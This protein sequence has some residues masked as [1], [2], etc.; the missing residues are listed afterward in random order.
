MQFAHVLLVEVDRPVH[1]GTEFTEIDILLV[2]M[3]L[4]PLDRLT[5]WR[6][7]WLF[8]YRV[9]MVISWGC[10]RIWGWFRVMGLILVCQQVTLCNKALLAFGAPEREPITGQMGPHVTNQSELVEKLSVTML[11]V[12]ENVVLRGFVLFELMRGLE[13]HAALFTIEGRNINIVTLVII[14]VVIVIY[15]L[16]ISIAVAGRASRARPARNGIGFVSLC[17]GIVPSRSRLFGF[18]VTVN[19]RRSF[20][21]RT[22]NV[23][24]YRFRI[25]G[26][27]FLGGILRPRQLRQ[28][29]RWRA[30]LHQ[31]DSYEA[32]WTSLDNRGG[33]PKPLAYHLGELFSEF[34]FPVFGGLLERTEYEGNTSTFCNA[35]GKHKLSSKRVNVKVQINVGSSVAIHGFYGW[36]IHLLFSKL[37]RPLVNHLSFVQGFRSSTCHH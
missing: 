32:L 31:G 30:V 36:L 34:G 17:A 20:V 14:V 9:S 33:D 37:K 8:G 35:L 3:K 19:R 12:V 16:W 24:T 23:F 7:T 6:K 22:W 1:L 21:V 18:L 11:A 2:R 25:G 26:E 28:L 10:F 5:G 29:G 13:G 15:V 4:W 27:A